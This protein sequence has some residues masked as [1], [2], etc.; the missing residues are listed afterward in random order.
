MNDAK[1][2][3]LLIEAAE[4]LINSVVHV[5]WK[6]GYNDDGTRKMCDEWRALRLEINAVR[7]AIA[8]MSGKKK[9]KDR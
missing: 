7:G 6:H 4:D 3:R 9:V 2:I 1:K 8:R 5:E